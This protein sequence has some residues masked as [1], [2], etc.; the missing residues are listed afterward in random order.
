MPAAVVAPFYWAENSNREV[1]TRLLNYMIS[2]QF[3]S[4]VC[5]QVLQSL[6]CLITLFLAAGSYR[7]DVTWEKSLEV[8]KNEKNI[9]DATISI[10]SHC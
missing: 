3:S 10:C 5:F 2:S 7:K 6:S 8:S 1:T 9:P 4:S